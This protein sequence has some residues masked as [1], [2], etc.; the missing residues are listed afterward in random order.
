MPT[1]TIQ[2][3]TDLNM[4]PQQQEQ[5]NQQNQSMMNND[6][7]SPQPVVQQQPQMNQQLNL[8]P[9]MAMNEPPQMNNELHVQALNNNGIIIQFHVKQEGE[10]FK[11]HATFS[12]TTISQLNNFSMKV[13][14]PKWIELE[15][16]NP[17]SNTIEPMTTDQVSQNL[18]L[19][20]NIPDKPVLVKI[21]VIYNKDGNNLE[22][23]ANVFVCN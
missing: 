19:K 21:K 10:E 14:V 7:L 23:N 2:L 18:I 5:N 12:N 13:A 8:D 3:T 22:E 6:L 20:R 15:L 16:M 9:F 17:T 1:N 4:I 11:V